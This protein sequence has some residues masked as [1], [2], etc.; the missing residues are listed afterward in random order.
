MSICKTLKAE[1]IHRVPL[2]KQSSDN[3]CSEC[4]TR[5]RTKASKGLIIKAVPD[6]LLELLHLDLIDPMQV[7]SLE[8]KIYVLVIVYDFSR[9]TW[10]KFIREKSNTFKIFRSLCLYL[11]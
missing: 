4:P 6:Q 9:F 5:K 10:V 7:E 1:A 2:L 8:G 3:I 11:P